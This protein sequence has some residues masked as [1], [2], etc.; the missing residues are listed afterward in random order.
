MIVHQ[1][2]D[3]IFPAPVFKETVLAPLFEIA[4]RQFVDAFQRVDRAHCV[5]LA[6]QNL[7]TKDHASAIARALADIEARFD[8]KGTSY[9]G[10][11]EDLFF[12]VERELKSRLGPDI[13]GRLHTGRSRNDIDHTVFKIVLKEKIDDLSTRARA[14][15]AGLIDKAEAEKATIVLAYTHG[16]PAQVSTY[17]HYLGA[18]IEVIEGDIR[19][20]MAARETVDQSSMGA[21]AITTTGF[22]LNRERIAALLGF[23]RIRLNSY[24][25]IASVDYISAPYAA[26]KLMML[27]LGRLTQDLQFWTA[28][29]VG[30]LHMPD[31]FVQISSIM[32]QKRNPV[33]I[34]H[35]RLL[36]SLAAGRAEGVI[37]TMHN[38]PFT[39]MNDAEGEVQAAA[40]LAFA[41]AGR[42]VDLV[43]GIIKASH[44]NAA[45]V[46]ENIDRSSA[47]I[48]ELA[49]TLVREEGLS[50]REAHEIAAA[51]ARAVT[52]AGSSLAAGGFAP[53]AEAFHH[54]TGRAGRMDEA[55]FRDA[56][57]P[58][59][60]I[61]LRNR[62]G[63]PAPAAMAVALARYREELAALETEAGVIANREAAQADELMRAFGALQGEEIAR[64]Q[65]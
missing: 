36:C 56:I 35:A 20:L 23:S 32:P 3:D 54:A 60:F 22:A 52:A 45:R 2:S 34:E 4:K 47:T 6:E 65:R 43:A 44:V 30:Q 11:V 10:E 17:G 37:M 61:V 7:L 26:I 59:R 14:L 42:A 58:E 24:G 48:T 49:D 9:T 13:A 40:H 38:T 33:P 28:F 15:L 25:C 16:Q 55:G 21:A 57:S 50:F 51:T 27:H 63:G 41:D 64:G 53:F 29:E 19:R 62:P 31:G 8:L 46:R 5:M 1:G 18:M 12:L 39:D